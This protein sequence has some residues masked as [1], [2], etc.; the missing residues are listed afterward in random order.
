MTTPE[1]II[2]NDMNTRYTYLKRRE[3]MGK[4]KEIAD[5][6]NSMQKGAIITYFNDNSH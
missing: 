5:K 1:G 2:N 6:L 3:G 4:T